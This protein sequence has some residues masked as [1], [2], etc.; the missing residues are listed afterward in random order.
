MSKLR[1]MAMAVALSM[2]APLG[3]Q[4]QED[5]AAT[6]AVMARLAGRSLLLDLAW[7]GERAVAVGERGQILVSDDRG[8]SW[9]QVPVP[10]SAGLTAVYFAD[11][12]HGWAVG[13][14]EL[15]LRTGD[16]GLTWEMTHLD[17]EVGQPL[18]DVWFADADRGIAVGAYGA[19]YSSVDGG[20]SWT[21]VAFE[22]EPLGGSDPQPAPDEYEEDVGLGFDFHLNAIAP[23]PGSTVYLAAEAG[24]LFRSDDGGAT[25]RELP[26][27]YD[28]SYYGLLMLDGEALLAF[29][30]R[31]HV[32]RSEDGGR[33]WTQVETGTTALLNAAIR[34]SPDLVLAVGLAGVML[35]SQDG[36]RSFTF[37]QQ[38]DRKGL[39]SL[40]W[41]G[42]GEVIVAGESGVRRLAV[43]GLR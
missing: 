33:N 27:P 43:P 18:L 10:A 14:D 23:G 5:A 17:I 6:P 19:M 20:R 11:A 39:S 37:T 12:Q 31:G 22:P 38:D 34:P 28:G 9:K 15:I 21:A 29:G 42:N 26:S 24:R 1:G 35:V 32:F 30:L 8:A 2:L 16:G 41:L 36:G 25:W 40:L 4:A 13:H 7:A 3:A